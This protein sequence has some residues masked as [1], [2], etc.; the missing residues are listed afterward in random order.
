MR[1]VVWKT[2]ICVLEMILV[3]I[4]ALIKEAESIYEM[5]VKFYQTILRN[6]AGDSH[7]LTG[8]HE[9]LK[10]RVFTPI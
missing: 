2:L 10:S 5:S 7:L 8:R 3:S 9:N 6:T 4:I 1:R